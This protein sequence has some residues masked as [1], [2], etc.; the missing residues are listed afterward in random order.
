VKEIASPTFQVKPV[1]GVR[2]V[3]VGG[4]FPALIATESVA[5]APLLSVTLRP[6]R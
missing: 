3:A 6:T 4:V 5:E 2:M 1:D